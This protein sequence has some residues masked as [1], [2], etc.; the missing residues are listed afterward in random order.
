MIIHLSGH[1]YLPSD[2]GKDTK[3][4][5]VVG[6]IHCEAEWDRENQI[7]ETLWLDKLS[8]TSKISDCHNWSCLV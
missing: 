1:N 2:Y 8:K 3:D 6:T 7:G 4:H 5:N